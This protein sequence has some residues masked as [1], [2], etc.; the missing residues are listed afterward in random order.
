MRSADDFVASLRPTRG[1]HHDIVDPRSRDMRRV[2]IY[3]TCLAAI[4]AAALIT[5]SVAS[6]TPSGA[7]AWGSGASGQLGNGAIADA[8][9]PTTVSGLSGVA[10]VSGGTS[11][12]LALLSGGTVKAWGNNVHGQLGNGTTTSSSVPV[13]VSGLSEVV[14]VEA[15]QS[16]GLAL[17]SNG[18]VKAWGDN[19]YGELGNGTTTASSTPVTVSGL[20]EVVAI[21]AGN[22]DSFALLANGKVEAWGNNNVGQLG[23]GSETGPEKCVVKE[24]LEEEV[25]EKEVEIEV[26]VPCSR[27][28]VEVSGLTEVSA[29]S[30]GA[31]HTLALLSNGTVK[32]WGAN[33]RGQLGDGTF[34]GPEI[35]TV[36]EA[37]LPEEEP[38]SRTPVAVSGL[39]EASAISAGGAHSMALLAAGAVEAWGY[40][41]QGQVGDGTTTSRDTP[42]EV[43]GL[44]EVTAISAGSQD[45]F[46]LLSGGTLKAWGY[47][48]SGRLGDG[49]TTKRTTPVAVSHA[50]EVAGISAGSTSTVAFGAPG[51]TYSTLSPD[52]G[53]IGGGT[54]VTITGANLANTLEVKFGASAGTGLVVVSSTSITVKAPPAAKLGSVS[55]VVLTST[56]VSTGG[57]KYTYLPEGKAELGR[58]VKVAKGTG[59]Y[60]TATCT[61]TVASGNFEWV[62]G[63]V[64]AGFT[65]SGEATTLESVE[66]A[67]VTCKAEHGSGEFVGTKQVGNVTVTLT[68]CESAT[69]GGA[70]CSTAGAAV[71]EIVTKTL[72]GAFGRESKETSKVGLD[73]FPTGETEQLFEASCGGTAVKVQG[74]V[75]GLV[76]PVNK[77][78][79]TLTTKYKATKGKQAI[80]HLDEEPNDVLG[81]SIGAGALHQTGLTLEVTQTNEEEV[82][83]NTIV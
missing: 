50:S 28:P 15:G 44:S 80:E 27:V 68:G 32:A 65:T 18:T 82:E 64:K 58:C 51:P 29:I 67:K 69:L 9:L 21:S 6:A 16:H 22:H 79:S 14:A 23:D 70:K 7:L 57:P 83:I 72:E 53:G 77:M 48:G 55:V 39:T 20:S 56:G 26:E 19:N 52:H 33:F 3:S 34:K 43:S 59:K 49:T 40:N 76:T 5:A 63:V 25:E 75:I 35:C 54:S 4:L 46:A 10:A 2:S 73:L 1:Q 41:N 17:L 47:N 81:M 66:K 36:I 31:T 62:P 37:G 8:S 42:V 11:F 71:G 38:C 60:K 24:S 78:S 12:D 61:E 30:A 74:S 45:S 13:A